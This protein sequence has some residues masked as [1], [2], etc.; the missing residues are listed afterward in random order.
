MG[1]RVLLRTEQF[2][3]SD[4]EERGSDLPTR[5]G[6]TAEGSLCV[7]S[8]VAFYLSLPQALD[9]T[10]REQPEMMVSRAAQNSFWRHMAG[11]TRLRSKECWETNIQEKTLN[12]ALMFQVGNTGP[13]EKPMLLTLVLGTTQPTSNLV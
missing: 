1:G 3:A 5:E 2:P 10:S 9:R 11:K 6:G 13:Q 7:T 4:L 12:P 8:Y